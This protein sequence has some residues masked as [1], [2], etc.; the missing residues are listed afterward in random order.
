MYM[1]YATYEYYIEKYYGTAVP[2]EVF[3]RVIRKAS[4]YIDHFTF[5]RIAEENVD[6]YTALPDCACDM[7][8]AIYSM[9]ES[10]ENKR[11]KKSES[12]DGYSVSYVTECVDGQSKEEVLKKKLY[13]IAKLYLSGTGL[14]YCGV[15]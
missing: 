9:L 3:P 2:D 14:L 4:Q 15:D 6:E 13:S 8:E 1:V 7:A 11:E 10:P 5:G 12:T